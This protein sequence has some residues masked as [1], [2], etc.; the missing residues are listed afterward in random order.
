MKYLLIATALVASSFVQTASVQAQ[1]GDVFVPQLSAAAAR[2]IKCTSTRDVGRMS[3]ALYKDGNLH[4]G[5][6]R[7]FLDQDHQFR[8]VPLM[9]RAS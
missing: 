1:S 6:G 7:T 9:L 5:R 4:G 8:P 2:K 3:N